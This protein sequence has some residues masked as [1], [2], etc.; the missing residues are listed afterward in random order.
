MRE[1]AEGRWA[2]E[3]HTETLRQGALLSSLQ[4]PSPIHP[5]AS[6]F[7]PSEGTPGP[8]TYNVAFGHNAALPSSPSFYIQGV[9]R[10]KKHETGPF[11][12][13]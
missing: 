13:L 4:L 6:L 1:E 11:T 5:L 9:R 8:G 2:P 7:H 10:P 3:A 12:T